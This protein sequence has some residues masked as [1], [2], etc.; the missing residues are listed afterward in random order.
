MADSIERA[1]DVLSSLARQPLY[2][3]ARLLPADEATVCLAALAAFVAGSSISTSVRP[4][5]RAHG[6]ARGARG[7]RCRPTRPR[8]DEAISSGD[9]PRQSV[10]NAII[11]IAS[12]PRGVTPVEIARPRTGRSDLVVGAGRAACPR[13][14]RRWQPREAR[15]FLNR[16]PM[17]RSV[18]AVRCAALGWRRSVGGAWL[19]AVRYLDRACV[20]ARARVRVLLRAARRHGPSHDS[21]ASAVALLVP[22]SSPETEKSS[23]SGR[24]CAAR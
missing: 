22:L 16:S 3:G 2:R 10:K 8:S 11:S 4:D 5:R 13:R 17:G 23:D 6:L 7:I 9:R 24:A 14:C 20:R 12:Q 18:S 1:G 15:S 19:A 21:R